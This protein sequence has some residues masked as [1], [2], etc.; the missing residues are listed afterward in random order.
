MHD[1]DMGHVMKRHD[2][3]MCCGNCGFYFR[4]S[5]FVCISIA[6]FLNLYFMLTSCLLHIDAVTLNCIGVLTLSLL[7]AHVCESF[8][9]FMLMHDY[10]VLSVQSLFGGRRPLSREGLSYICISSQSLPPSSFLF[11]NV[12]LSQQ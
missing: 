6:T 11:T 7:C 8:M 3:N 9:G 10:V 5:F 4:E 2:W 1:S 12:S